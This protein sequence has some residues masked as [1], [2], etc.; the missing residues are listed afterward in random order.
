M[1]AIFGNYLFQQEPLARIAHTDSSLKK[2]N[3]LF[4]SSFPEQDASLFAKTD[5]HSFEASRNALY[6]RL[7]KKK[8]INKGKDTLLHLNKKP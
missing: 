7:S 8:N 4:K 1:S 6:R 3:D 5:F 2:I